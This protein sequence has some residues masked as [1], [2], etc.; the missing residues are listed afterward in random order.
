MG[1][2]LLNRPECQYFYTGTFCANMS[3]V[4]ILCIVNQYA[5]K[6]L[7]VIIGSGFCGGMST[8]S[9]LCNE[10]M[11][12][13]FKSHEEKSVQIIMIAYCYIIITQVAGCLMVAV[14]IYGSPQSSVSL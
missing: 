7:Q 3:A 11:V 1:G 8:L 9:S 10:F 14:F 2:V 6:T 4:L 5:G 12:A 13:V